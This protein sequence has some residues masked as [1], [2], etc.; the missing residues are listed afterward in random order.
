MFKA[1]KDMWKNTFNYTGTVIRKEYW[2]ALIMN[3]IVMYVGVIPYALIA[4]NITDNFAVVVTIYLVAIH[5][6]TL[7]IYFRRARDA[8]WK[9]GTAV[10][11]AIITPIISGLI[12]GIISN[13]RVVSKGYSLVAKIFALS[14]GLYFY[15]GVLGIILYDDPT[16]IPIV[17]MLGLL[18]GSFTLICYGVVNWRKVLAFLGGSDID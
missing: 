18:L 4:K 14:F 11:L 9:M 10:Y 6:P 8:G 12:V 1:W 2:L 13:C 7:A 5:L 16:A 15:G 17:L 3:V